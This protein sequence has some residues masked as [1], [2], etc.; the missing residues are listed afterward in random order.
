MSVSGDQKQKQFVT[1]LLDRRIGVPD[2]ITSWTTS[3]A[4]RRFGIYRGNVVGA[5]TE[6]LAAR[7]PVVHRLV[8]EQFFRAMA[9]GYVHTTLPSSPVLIVYG[10]DFPDFIA[11]FEPAAALPYLAD[12]A[13]FES[14]HWEAYHA[15]DAKPLERAAFE[16]LDPNEFANAKFVMLPS[17]RVV[18]STYPILSIWRTNTLDEHVAD[19]DLSK[20]EDALIA[21]PRMWVEVCPLEPGEAMLYRALSMGAPFGEA[22]GEALERV[23]GLDVAR[24]VARVISGQLAVRVLEGPSTQ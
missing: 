17:L 7:Y 9:G 13:R 20:A 19:V 4:S 22:A 11:G 23:P 2:G 3:S 16:G 24:V 8:G 1:A 18:T 10:T 6:A 12:V 5:L 15:E 21:R 14:A